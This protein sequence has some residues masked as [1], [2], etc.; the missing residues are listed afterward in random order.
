MARKLHGLKKI[1]SGIFS[2]QGKHHVIGELLPHFALKIA[3]GSGLN[4]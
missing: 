1:R 4:V 3:W 2:P